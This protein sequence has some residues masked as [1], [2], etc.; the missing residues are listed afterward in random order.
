MAS[1]SEFMLGWG[2]L[3]VKSRTVFNSFVWFPRAQFPYNRPGQALAVKQTILRDHV[4]M[5]KNMDW[6]AS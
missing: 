2:W 5:K 3:I 6:G 4:E 1:H